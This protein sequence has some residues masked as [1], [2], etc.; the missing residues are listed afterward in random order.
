MFEG[1]DS[2]YNFITGALAGSY[3]NQFRPNVDK[4]VHTWGRHVQ[5]CRLIRVLPSF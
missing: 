5:D 4:Y 3:Q 1:F 2:F